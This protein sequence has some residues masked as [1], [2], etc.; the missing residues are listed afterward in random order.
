MRFLY[1]LVVC[2]A[3]MGCLATKAVCEDSLGKAN[4]MDSVYSGIICNSEQGSRHGW[5]PE[6]TTEHSTVADAPAGTFPKAGTAE[7]ERRESLRRSYTGQTVDMNKTVTYDVAKADEGDGCP[8]GKDCKCPP[9]VCKKKH[10]KMN[11]AIM[12]S[13]SW[14]GPCRAMYPTLEKLRE[15]GYL[16]YIYRI[17]EFKNIDAQFDVNAFPTFIVFDK[18][19]EVARTVGITDKEWFKT[20]LKTADEQK[21][22]PEPPVHPVNP[23]DEL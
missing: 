1:G 3:G 19:K 15:E 11:Y 12:I 6:K 9:N 23:Y 16:I 22:K 8:C 17:D 4:Q 13:A 14:C 21:K 10:C 5:V 2:L 18:G 20:N 7:A